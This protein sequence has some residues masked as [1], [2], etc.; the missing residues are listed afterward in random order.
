MQDNG[1]AI[2][3]KIQYLSRVCRVLIT[4]AT[5]CSWSCSC[6]SQVQILT[7]ATLVKQ[8][9]NWFNSY[10]LGFWT[11]LNQIHFWVFVYLIPSW[12]GIWKCWFLRREEGWSTWRIPLRAREWTNNKLNPYNGV[13]AGMWNPGHSDGRWLLSPLSHPHF[14]CFNSDMTEID[15]QNGQHC[16]V[17]NFCLPQPL[18]WKLLTLDI[19]VKYH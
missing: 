11:I 1:K 15:K 7:W 17:T 6:K 14:P 16:S 19:H 4:F 3:A 8:T 13:D 12:S 10:Q 9:A 18:L 2:Q 5:S